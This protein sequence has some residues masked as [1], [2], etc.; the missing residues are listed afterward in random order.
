M[1]CESLYCRNQKSETSTCEDF[2]QLWICS[3]VDLNVV[4]SFSPCFWIFVVLCSKRG[5]VK[6]RVF[7][8]RGL[9]REGDKTTR[10]EEKLGV[11]LGGSDGWKRWKRRGKLD[12]VKS[13]N[14]QGRG[15]WDL[16]EMRGDYMVA[17]DHKQVFLFLKNISS[18]LELEEGKRVI[19]GSFWLW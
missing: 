9:L 1:E 14:T 6:L 11:C 13:S 3:L 19:C 17:V 16:A 10:S 8:A 5:I 15:R 12:L 4:W 18:F 7:C 2:N